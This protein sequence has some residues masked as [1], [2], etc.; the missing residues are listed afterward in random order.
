M[1]AWLIHVK[2]TEHATIFQIT[3]PARVLEDIQVEIVKSLVLMKIFLTRLMPFCLNNE[4]LS[5][6]FLAI[7]FL[8]IIVSLKKLV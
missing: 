6:I 4:Q 8:F 1:N 3:T 7:T 2:I 5:D